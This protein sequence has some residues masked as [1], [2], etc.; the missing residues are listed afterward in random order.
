MGAALAHKFTH[1]GDVAAAAAPPLTNRAAGDV[2]TAALS[3]L[4]M[5][6][7][8]ILK[9]LVSCRFEESSVEEK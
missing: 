9:V 6:G 7:M 4:A 3:P 8:S 1:A 2:C 5:V